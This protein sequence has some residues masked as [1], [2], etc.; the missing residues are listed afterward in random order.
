MYMSVKMEKR[1]ERVLDL[2]LS[3]VL[4]LIFGLLVYTLFSNWY[5][6]YMKNVEVLVGERGKRPCECLGK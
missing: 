3:F 1:R 2:A 5:N 4:F 6:K